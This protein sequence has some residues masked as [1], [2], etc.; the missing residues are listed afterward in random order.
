ML[1]FYSV[2][3]SPKMETKYSSSDVEMGRVKSSGLAC[4]TFTGIIRHI[5]LSKIFHSFLQVSFLEKTCHNN[6]KCN[7]SVYSKK[8][9]LS[10]KL[11]KD[12]S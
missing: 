10:L 9:G 3:K 7:N 4:L 6:Q 2:F 1:N 11:K 5:P 12:K 8:S